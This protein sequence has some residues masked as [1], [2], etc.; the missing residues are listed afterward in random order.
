MRATQAMH[1]ASGDARRRLVL[2][3]G[4]SLLAHAWLL[5]SHYGKDAARGRAGEET[6]RIVAR[7]FPVEP[8]VITA[9]PVLL[10]ERDVVVPERH[11]AAEVPAAAVPT[12]VTSATS[13]AL[14][15]PADPTYYAA[16]DLDVFP[17]ALVKPDLGAALA[18]R[19]ARN[20]GAAGSVRALVLI[21]EAGLVDAVRDV[22]APF[23][24]AGAVARELL[25]NTRFTPARN[26]DGRVVKAQ[27]VV[28][29]ESHAGDTRAAPRAQ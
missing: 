5:Q 21:D 8:S 12:N 18:A 17:R 24:E 7:I 23:G 27:V 10:V 6:P 9:A 20:D 29:L 3:L 11:A 25:L 2:A 13:A 22:Q 14:A 26:K 28:V 1:G 4:L 19:G 16:G 15:P